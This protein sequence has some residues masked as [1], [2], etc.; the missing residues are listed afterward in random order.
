MVVR[1]SAE[2]EYRTMVVAACEIT[3]PRQ[4][5]QQPK[6]GDTQNTKLICDNQAVIHIASNPVFHERT[7]HNEIDCHFVTEKVLLG[8]IITDFVS[9]SYQLADI[10]TKSLKG[11]HVHNICNKLESY[12]I[13][14]LAWGGLLKMIC[15]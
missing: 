13:Y 4:L 2:A 8:E 15:N 12:D 14:A 3:W 5:L 1:S 6:C 7:K 11:S 10:F 9:S